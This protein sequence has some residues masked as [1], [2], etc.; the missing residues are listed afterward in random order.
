MFIGDSFAWGKSADP[1]TGHCFVDLVRNETGCE[2]INL[3]IP[4]ADPAQY[5]AL[6][7]KYIPLLKPGV[8]F[9]MFFM[10]NDL[11]VED[12]QVVPG[13]PFCFSTNQGMIFADMDGRFFPTAQLAYNYISNERYYLKKPSNCFTWL[14]SKSALLSRLY[15]VKFRIK[16]KL[17][18]EKAVNES[19]VT[20]KYL[21]GIQEI[22]KA[23]HSDIK[24]VLIP[25]FKEA[26]LDTAKYKRRYA[27]LL[28]DSVLQP[29][30][31]VLNNSKKNFVG[32]PDGHLNNTGHR[33]YADF[34][35]GYSK[36]LHWPK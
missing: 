23:Y 13:R 6:A 32:Y 15:S 21:K 33:Y 3:G 7:K 2:V 4:G 11:M 10:G 1:L 8:V 18:Y 34:L 28:A 5:Y 26:G 31:L 27:S 20:K 25:E 19:S 35:E 24:F 16:E 30:W 22:S 36:S 14:I 29:N 17:A 9:V 12:R